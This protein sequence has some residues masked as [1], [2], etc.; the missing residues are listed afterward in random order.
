M[1]IDGSTFTVPA[2]P[3]LGESGI[4]FEAYPFLGDVAQGM[5]SFVL[6]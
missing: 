6:W 5:S 2:V 3:G 1:T 4:L